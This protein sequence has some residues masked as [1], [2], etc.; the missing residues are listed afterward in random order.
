MWK[1]VPRN[2]KFVFGPSSFMSLK[3]V[4]TEKGKIIAEDFFDCC[5]KH[6]F[7]LRYT[8]RRELR[9]PTAKAY[10]GNK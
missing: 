8:L 5:V 3:Y 9:L 6:T 2:R 10:A 4:S 1:N 7:S